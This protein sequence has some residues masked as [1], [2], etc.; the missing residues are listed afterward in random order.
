MSLGKWEA[1]RYEARAL[2]EALRDCSLPWALLLIFLYD[3]RTVTLGF[4]FFVAK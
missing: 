4:N 2:A 1:E 3:L